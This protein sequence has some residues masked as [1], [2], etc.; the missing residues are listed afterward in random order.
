PYIY[1]L[2]LHD[3][4]PISNVKSCNEDSQDIIVNMGVVRQYMMI[5]NGK[6]ILFEF[7]TIYQRIR[8]EV[9]MS[10]KKVV[11]IGAGIV[12]A[13]LATLIDRKSTRLNSSHVSI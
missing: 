5:N 7:E 6:K 11:L 4:L 3:A 10:N 9:D 1:N 13:T 12:S 2:S 8:S